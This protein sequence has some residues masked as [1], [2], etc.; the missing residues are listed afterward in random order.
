MTA[1]SSSAALRCAIGRGM[2]DVA[3]IL[4]RIGQEQSGFERISLP[5]VVVV[6]RA[7]VP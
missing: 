4:P 1:Q 5:A 2:R 6:L 7:D 3:E